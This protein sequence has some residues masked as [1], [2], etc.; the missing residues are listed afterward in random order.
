MISVFTTVTLGIRLW[1]ISWPDEAAVD[2]ASVGRIVNAYIKGEY[3]FD[4]QPPLGKLILAA[5]ASVAGY[6]GSYTFDQSDDPYPSIPY[7]SMRAAVS[8]MGA[9]CSP[10]AYITLKA[11]SHSTLAAMLAATLVAFDNALTAS[12]RQM[13]LDAP[14]LFFTAATLMSCTLFT[15]CSPRPFALSWWAW[16]L[17]TGVFMAGAVSVKLTGILTAAFVGLFMLQDLWRLARRESVTVG[18]WSQHCAARIGTLLVLPFVLYLTIFQIHFAYQ[19]REPDYL[20]SAQAENDLR[21]LPPPFRHALVPRY[22]KEQQEVWRDVV[23]GSV[24][25]LQSESQSQSYL[26][27]FYKLNPGGSHQQQV[28]GYEYPDLN[29]HWIVI[30]ADLD[31]DEPEEIPSRLQY[32]KNGDSLRL[33]H[34]STRRCLHAHDVRT[35]GSLQG[36]NLHEVTAYGGVAF[37]GDANDWWQV[38]QVDTDQMRET[39]DHDEGGPIKALETA[40]RLRHSSLGCYLYVSETTLPEPWGQG[41]REIVCR[42]DAGVTP[43]SI[44]RFTMNEHDYLPADALLAASPTPSFWQKFKYMHRL[45]WF[46]ANRVESGLVPRTFDRFASTPQQ[47]LL[48]NSVI[49]VWTGYMRQVVIIAN[50]VVWWVSTLGLLSFIILKVF[51][52][53][54]TKRGYLETGLLKQLKTQQL[55]NMSTFFAA[56]AIHYM[57]F[58]CVDRMLYLH[59][60]F[61]ALYC[62][63]LLASSLFSVVMEFFSRQIRYL[64]LSSLVI[65]CISSFAQ[66]APLSYGSLMTRGHCESVSRWFN[67]LDCSIAPAVKYKLDAQHIPLSTQ[68]KQRREEK[69]PSS[70]ALQQE[71]APTAQQPQATNGPILSHAGPDVDFLTR[72]AV[73]PASASASALPQNAQEGIQGRY[74][75]YRQ[76]GI[77]K[78]QFRKKPPV[79]ESFFPSA[80]ELQPMQDVVL[81]PYQISPQHWDLDV[82]NQMLGR[83]T[84]E[85]VLQQLHDLIRKQQQQRLAKENETGTIQESLGIQ[86]SDTNLLPK[87][88]PASVSV[89]APPP[90]MHSQG[91]AYPADYEGRP[92]YQRREQMI[93]AAAVF[94][95]NKKAQVRAE[96][97]MLLALF[98]TK[99]N[100]A[101]HKAKEKEEVMR[102][103]QKQKEDMAS[104]RGKA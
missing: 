64:F 101:E 41:R 14:L 49:P 37:D 31:K 100:L 1:R 60:Y 72:E 34:V 70:L 9:L 90:P 55:G 7:G 4:A 19:T 82:L 81:L 46:P 57:P 51:F 79:L 99:D 71:G 33:R 75:S 21:L 25:R 8:S 47:W 5:V 61:P 103:L 89:D 66:L 68:R 67:L 86:G 88:P 54:R 11:T 43:K 78:Q 63:I 22:P 29:T 56:W 85:H 98:P 12:N 74:S 3:A 6:S 44:W 59:H 13:L 87:R 40:F 26:H 45:M 92:D 83:W 36:K 94:A 48:P 32:L 35:Y 15:K 27:S 10:M 16:L 20:N 50:P 84:D 18:Q 53:L 28:G 42:T 93:A 23:Y 96:R 73:L 39:V 38:E 2:E 69:G 80:N 77:E 102:K 104:S 30:L 95:A 52:V 91:L 76:A 62:T 24:V 65:L 17:A 97:D 58:F